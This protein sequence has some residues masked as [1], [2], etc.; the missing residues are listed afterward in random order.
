MGYRQLRGQCRRVLQAV[1]RLRAQNR[2]RPEL[3]WWG[4]PPGWGKH[5]AACISADV[6]ALE[7]TMRRGCAWPSHSL[8][9][10]A[11]SLTP[12]A[13]RRASGVHRGTLPLWQAG[14]TAMPAD[15]AEPGHSGRSVGV[16]RRQGG[17]QGPPP[18]VL[19]QAPG[20]H[21]AVLSMLQPRGRGRWPAHICT[22]VQGRQC[23]LITARPAQAIGVVKFTS[24]HHVH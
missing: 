18:G 15:D 24:F 8:Q 14:V 6:A 13:P 1:P 4:L 20:E 23:S 10:K 16:V 7:A 12:S 19:A 5:A 21:F 9:L 3:Q 2:Q 11:E 17:L 22:N